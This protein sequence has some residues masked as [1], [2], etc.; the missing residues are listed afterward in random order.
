MNESAL[1][2]LESLPT[3]M[4]AEVGAL[5][6][7]VTIERYIDFLDMMVHYT[8]KS[9]ERLRFA[10]KT[11]RDPA[12]CRFFDELAAEEKDHYRLAEADLAAF[13]RAPSAEE[14]PEVAAFHAFWMGI[15]GAHELAFLGAL[16]VLEGVADKIG[17]LARQSLGKLGL[18]KTRARFILVHLDVDT[19]H[20]AGAHALATA[21]AARDPESL[22]DG[23]R[24]AAAFWVAIHRRALLA[25]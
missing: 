21:L 10:A 14:P 18:D 4:A 3:Q 6:P 1:R 7:E 23:A 20:G 8:K 24:K 2:E 13:G 19:A 16:F 25:E 22:L 17:A 9:G 12:L 15:D 11:A 5:L